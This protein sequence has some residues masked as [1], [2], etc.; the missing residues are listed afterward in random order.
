MAL[1]KDDLM[2]KIKKK[3]V[4]KGNDIGV[5]GKFMYVECDSLQYKSFLWMILK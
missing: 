3:I 4:E 2:D 1:N 5:L